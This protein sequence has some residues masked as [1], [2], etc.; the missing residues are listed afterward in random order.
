MTAVN[1]MSSA[2]SDFT[3][4]LVSLSPAFAHWIAC[5]DRFLFATG[6]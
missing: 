2:T 4:Q 6:M 3:P 1:G 5:P